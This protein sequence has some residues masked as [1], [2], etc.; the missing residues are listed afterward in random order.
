M[1][2]LAN[3]IGSTIGKV[4]RDQRVISLHN[5]ALEFHFLILNF[6]NIKMLNLLSM[7]LT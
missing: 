3:R 5:K 4:I 7:L 6:W 2:R 1:L